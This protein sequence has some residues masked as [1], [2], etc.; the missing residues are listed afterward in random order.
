MSKDRVLII[1]DDDG[2]REATTL[3]LQREGY[4]ATS[5][6]SAESALPI[7]ESS[8]QQLVILD[9]QLPGM[10]GL[11][12]LKRVRSR[13]PETAVIVTTAFG[14][15]KTAV[16][17]MKAGASDYVSKPVQLQDL[18]ELVKRCLDQYHLL[19]GC[20][21]PRA[22]LDGGGG[23]DR[24]VGSSDVFLA[25]L[26]VAARIAPTDTT[27]LLSGETGTG[28]ELVARSIHLRSQRREHP[29]TT[30]NCGAIPRELLESELFGHVKGAFT[31]ALTNKKGKVEM[32][33]GGTVLLDEIG[34]MPLDLQ[35]RIL[36]LIQEHEIEKIGGSAPARVDV[37]IIAATHR[38]LAAMV[39]QGTFREDLYYRLL[40]VPIKLPPLRERTG[41][42]QL[43]VQHFFTKCKSKYQRSELTLRPDLL[44]YFLEYS[45][46]GNVRELE[47]A[48]ERM[49]LLCDCAELTPADLPDFMACASAEEDG[50]AL[51]LPPAGMSIDKMER[52]MILQ[53]L[54]QCGGNQTHAARQLG[55]SR[56]TLAYRLEKY[57]IYGDRLKALKHG[58][59]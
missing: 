58:A 8:A 14:T 18:K 23:F 52:Q 57:G 27:V 25:A 56:R 9:L 54:R 24:I 59:A 37:R 16:E 3:E 28:K 22:M 49:V 15:V 40:V 34:E 19:R 11:D 13:H 30:I 36:R 1:E 50:A 47:N 33:G 2:L 32:A 12:L 38:N 48:I 17:A 46:P 5:V 39:K 55:M 53:A 4:E 45:W 44:R 43:L 21:P 20:Q 6:F 41:D 51:V 35:V 7:L 29:F 10:S 42:I 31:G 26:E